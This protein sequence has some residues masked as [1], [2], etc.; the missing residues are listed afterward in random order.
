MARRIKES[1]E[2][3][4]LLRGTFSFMRDDRKMI[5]VTSHRREN[6]GDGLLAICRALLPLAERSDIQIVYLARSNPSVKKPVEAVL[7]GQSNIT[8]ISPQDYLSFVYLMA[9]GH[10]ILMDSGGM[11]EEAPSL[12]GPVLV[13]RDTTERPGAIAV[14]T[15]RLVGDVARNIVAHTRRLLDDV[16]ACSAMSGRSNPYGDGQAA[17]G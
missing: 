2:V 17:P 13:M 16:K 10:I 4:S 3:S 1:V 15:V 8:L 9:R 6:F 12:G 14:G 5:L 11:R 7:A